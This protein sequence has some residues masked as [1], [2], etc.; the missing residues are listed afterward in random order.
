MLFWILCILCEAQIEVTFVQ[1][2][3]EDLLSFVF[4]ED[5]T[6]GHMREALP[7]EFKDANMILENS[8]DI[9]NDEQEF[10]D[11][12]IVQG[13]R[14]FVIAKVATCNLFS[15][16]FLNTCSNIVPNIDARQ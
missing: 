14:I 3:G 5:K 10:A 15:K 12:G 13:S 9:L 11:A 16:T 7:E 6:V 2:S 4:D 8:S 1:L